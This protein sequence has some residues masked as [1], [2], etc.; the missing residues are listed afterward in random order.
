MHSQLSFGSLQ[1][2]HCT[3]TTAVVHHCSCSLDKGKTWA[4]ISTWV[5]ATLHCKLSPE[6][7]LTKGLF[8]CLCCR[9]DGGVSSNFGVRLASSFLPTAGLDFFHFTVQWLNFIFEM[10][11]NYCSG[12]SRICYAFFGYLSRE[13]NINS[14]SKYR[15]SLSALSPLSHV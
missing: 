13:N 10:W 7:N 9:W 14:S 6:I 11:H 12:V 8:W 4:E 2:R 15:T 3:A 5:W 1:H